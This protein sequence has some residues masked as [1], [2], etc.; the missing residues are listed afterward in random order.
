LNQTIRAFLTLMEELHVLTGQPAIL[1]SDATLAGVTLSCRW[2]GPGSRVVRITYTDAFT[3]TT[4]VLNPAGQG[5]VTTFS[6]P[7]STFERARLSGLL[8]THAAS[9]L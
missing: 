9:A 1:E 2:G 3:F 5:Q 4:Q 7:L 8:A 6:I